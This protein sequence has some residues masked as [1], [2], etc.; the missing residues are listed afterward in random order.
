MN[1]DEIKAKLDELEV[2]YDPNSTK[3]V[4]KAL[5][6]E[7]QSKNETQTNLLD[8]VNKAVVKEEEKDETQQDDTI[9]VLKSRPYGTL[10]RGQ[11]ELLRQNSPEYTN[12]DGGIDVVL[13]GRLATEKR[14][15][16]DADNNWVSLFKNKTYSLS[17]KDYNSLK[18][19]QVRVKT[20]ATKDKCCGNAEYE[21]VPLLVKV[22]A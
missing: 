7:Q 19:A 21:S 22:D 12:V 8:V 18:D 6:D 11:R 3:D 13:N 17:E 10:T 5:L 1:K 14:L 9:E 16:K 15:V 20:E 2:E 4:L